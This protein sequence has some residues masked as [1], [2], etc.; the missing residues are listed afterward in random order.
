MTAARR[1]TACAI[2]VC[3][4]SSCT[5]GADKRL[6]AGAAPTGDSAARTSD[7]IPE[8]R[9]DSVVTTPPD[10]T[11][12][13]LALLPAPA[14]TPLDGEAASLAD[15]AVFTPRVQRWFMARLI[16]SAIVLDVGRIDGGVGASASAQAAFERMIRA[17]SPLQPGALLTIHTPTGAVPARITSFAMIGRRIVARLDAAPP[18]SSAR[19]FPAEWRGEPPVALPAAS[20][21]A[22]PCTTADA[23]AVERAIAGYAASDKDVLT[24]VRGCFGDFRAVV[25]IR[26]RE[27]TPESVERV[28]L[29]RQ[30]GGTR[31]GK[32]RDLSYP[33]HE[34]SHVVDVNRDGTNEIVVHSYRP[35]METWAT[36]RM[37]DSITFTRFASGFTIE[38]R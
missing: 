22:A 27:I 20:P 11:T 33:L 4:T 19:T 6:S 9:P 12:M 37:T 7:S 18:D 38:K 3:L 28:M 17:R 23:A 24:V 5:G 30:T 26:P 29:V 32:L 13:L 36:L 16:D 10:S 25:I 8:E 15:R 35:A 1:W 21:T 2:V 34:L 14:R 31:S